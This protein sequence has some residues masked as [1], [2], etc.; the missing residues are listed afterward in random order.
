MICDPPPARNSRKR[1][2]GYSEFEIR[3]HHALVARVGPRAGA[4]VPVPVAIFHCT[5]T[6]NNNIL[7]VKQRSPSS[8]PQP[9][10]PR[11]PLTPLQLLALPVAVVARGERP[12][13]AQRRRRSPGFR[14]GAAGAPLRTRSLSAQAHYA[15][16]GASDCRALPRVL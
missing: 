6:T 1:N 8:A 12:V 15:R 16:G 2:L 5:D 10:A 14:H 11:A 9:P 3:T 13:H 7:R 4:A